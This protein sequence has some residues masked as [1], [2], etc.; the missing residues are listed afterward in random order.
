MIKKDGRVLANK[1]YNAQ[2]GIENIL[3]E[4]LNEYSDYGMDDIANDLI[5]ISAGLEVV[6]LKVKYAMVKE[7]EE[8]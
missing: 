2:K 6:R 4:H 7:K 1:I 3:E 8:L 5:N